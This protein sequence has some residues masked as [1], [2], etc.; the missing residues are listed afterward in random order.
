M[1]DNKI[2]GN[3]KYKGD[4][5]L[6]DRGYLEDEAIPDESR[7]RYFTCDLIKHNS[8]GSSYIWNDQPNKTDPEPYIDEP[9]PTE[10]AFTKDGSGYYSAL[11]VSNDFACNQWKA[12]DA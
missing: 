6:S 3:C 12:K 10:I 11:C 7:E 8:K 9:V 4:D 2:C 1:S 5:L